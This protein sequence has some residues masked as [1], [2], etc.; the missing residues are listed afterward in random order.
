MW[1]RL[2]VG[3]LGVVAPL[4]AADRVFTLA[5]DPAIVNHWP[6]PDGFLG[7]DD[8]VVQNQLS[9]ILQ[10]S[11]NAMGSYGYLATSLAGF[12]D[13]WLP[14]NSDAATFLQGSITVDI[15]ASQTDEIPVFKS[16]E[17]QGTELFPGHGAYTVRL[18]RPH[19][20]VYTRQG[21]EYGFSIFYDFEGVFA[22]GLA[23][24]T[25]A[26]AT[27]SAYL[28][29]S[30]DFAADLENPNNLDPLKSWINQVA[31]PLA[32]R[33]QPNAILCGRA[34]T[35]TGAANPGTPGSFPPLTAYG[36]FIAVETGPLV[37]P[38]LRITRV[39]LT[40]DGVLIE[41]SAVP[42]KTYRIDSSSTVT[43]AFQTQARTGI[44]T[45]FVD[46]SVSE[47]SQR[48]YRIVAE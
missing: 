3:A 10:S 40:L 39:S 22:G 20:G 21:L 13:S 19:D 43:G 1:W 33:R 47:S 35:S 31:L 34:T 27:G 23:R 26:Q 36:T 45:R 44:E 14:N 18:T 48:Y 17:F 2:L 37:T 12:Q 42:G 28:I 8:D 46:L 5:T 16:L 7:T 25:N 24:S 4:I 41:W 15:S 6:G 30:L 38:T 32:R 29:E 9:Q 11:P